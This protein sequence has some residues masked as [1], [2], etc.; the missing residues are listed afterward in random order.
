M[1]CSISSADISD[2]AIVLRGGRSPVEFS[3]RLK[4]SNHSRVLERVDTNEI[5]DCLS[6]VW[7]SSCRLFNP[8][9][10]DG[11]RPRTDAAPSSDRSS[12]HL[13]VSATLCASLTC[14]IDI[15]DNV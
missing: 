12:L 6:L 11:A 9:T 8:I 4:A 5:I 15:F 3:E 14:G 13:T 2:G 7:S 10:V 1:E